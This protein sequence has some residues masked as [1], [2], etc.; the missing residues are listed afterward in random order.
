MVLY[1][2][3]AHRSVK[4]WKRLFFHLIDVTL[5]NSHRFYKTATSSHMTQL[6]FKQEVTKSLVEGHEW[7]HHRQHSPAPNIPLFLT[8]RA[9]PEPVP[10][11]KRQ[12]CKV[13]SNK[14]EPASPNSVYTYV[15]VS[16]AMPTTGVK[17][18]SLHEK[19]NDNHLHVGIGIKVGNRLTMKNCYLRRQSWRKHWVSPT[20]NKGVGMCFLAQNVVSP[21]WGMYTHTH[22]LICFHPMDGTTHRLASTT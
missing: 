3:F 1:Y 15:G 8:E 2:S 13:C 14:R 11:G 16:C 19:V 12:D 22:L 9:F 7:S 18:N 10:E 6:D 5:V 21:P 20:C 4:W 17:G